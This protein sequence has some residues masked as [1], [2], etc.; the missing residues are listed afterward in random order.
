M[1]YFYFLKKIICAKVKFN[2]SEKAKFRYKVLAPKQMDLDNK[3]DIPKI[4]YVGIPILLMWWAVVF[5]ALAF[6]SR[7]VVISKYGSIF[8]FIVSIPI[9]GILAIKNASKLGATINSE[10]QIII[11]SNIYTYGFKRHYV[12]KIDLWYTSILVIGLL[13]SFFIGRYFYKINED[14]LFG[15]INNKE[16]IFLAILIGLFLK[17]KFGKYKK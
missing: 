15:Y 1:L 9:Y 7:D 2:S 16:I 5:V 12:T 17:I 11:N 3:P 4:V 10:E 14:Q 6:I 13:L 8:I